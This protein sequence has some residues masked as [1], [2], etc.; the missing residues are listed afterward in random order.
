M[1]KPD[2]TTADDRAVNASHE[3]TTATNGGKALL[4]IGAA[5]NGLQFGSVLA[6][7]QDGI[8]IQIER[9]EKTRLEK[10]S[11]TRKRGI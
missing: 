2:R 4:R 7:V 3:P 6:I 8:V 5:L 1:N 11:A 9:T 10:P